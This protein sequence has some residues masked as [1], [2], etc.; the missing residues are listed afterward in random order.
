MDKKIIELDDT[1]IKEY[2][3]HEYKSP[4]STNDKDIN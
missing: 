1:K 2:E 3:F 4:T